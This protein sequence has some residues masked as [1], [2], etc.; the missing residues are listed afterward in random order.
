MAYTYSNGSYASKF[1]YVDNPTGDW[2]DW[3]PRFR[4]ERIWE[5]RLKLSWYHPVRDRAA[6]VQAKKHLDTISG[7]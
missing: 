2:R 1:V 4:Q 6:W 3:S 5:A 7:R